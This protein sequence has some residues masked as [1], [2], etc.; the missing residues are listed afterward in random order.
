MGESRR[1][2]KSNIAFFGS[3]QLVA[4]ERLLYRNGEAV[5]LGSRQLDLLTAL[6]ERSGE[7]LSQRELMQRAWP[8][9][10]V[11]DVNLRVHIGHLRKI[12]RDGQEGARFITNVPGRGYCFVAPVRWTEQLRP[13]ES[14]SEGGGSST[15]SVPRLPPRLARMIGREQ[16]VAELK[17]MLVASRFVSV[18]G[19][20]G[21]GKTTTAVSVA[22][23]LAEYFQGSVFFV[24][25]APLSET[26]LLPATVASAVGYRPLSQN[27]LD[28]LIVFLL[29]RRV[30]LVL[31][32]CEHVIEGAAELTERL[33]RGTK[34]VHIL[35]TS[36]ESLRVEGE[37]VHLL[38][39]LESPPDGPELTV[40]S[41]MTSPA[42]RLFMDR[43][44]A[45]GYRSG[46][47]D[48]DA[49]VVADICR[50]LDGVPL[51]I[52]LV[53][54][55]VGVYGI[56]GTADLLGHRF[57]LL[58]QGR[59][60]A[61]PRHQTLSAM[62]DW[63]YNLLS[64]RDRQ[65]LCSL[66]VFTGDFTLEEAQAITD[67]AVW[68]PLDVALAVGSLVDKSLI[69]TEGVDGSTR[70]RLLDTTRGY[71]SAKLADSGGQNAA[72]RRHALY[73]CNVLKSA[74]I[75]VRS[76]SK[77]DLSPFAAHV[78][79]VRAALEWSFSS[80]SDRTIG[81]ELAA[82]AT[83]LFRGLFLLGD[84]QHWCECGLA[85]LD[86][87]D[88]GTLKELTLQEGLAISAMLTRGNGAEVRTAIERGLALAQSLNESHHQLQLLAGLHLHL[89][90]IN[91]FRGA[92]AIA[93]R[94]AAVAGN[95]DD[96]EARIMTEW[97]L[98]TSHYL[99]GKLDI[100]QRHCDLGFKHDALRASNLFDFF[101]YNHR[102]RALIVQARL[103]WLRGFP[104]R[105][106]GTARQAMEEAESRADP[107]N[108]CV[109]LVFTA[110]IFI[111]RGDF[112]IAEHCINRIGAYAARHGLQ[113]YGNLGVALQGEL[114]V[115]RGEL[116]DGTELLRGALAELKTER[117]LWVIPRFLPAFSAAL[118]QR[119]YFEE[120]AVA[121]DDMISPTQQDVDALE[122]P[123]LLR[124]RA[125]IWLTQPAPDPV[126]AELA[127]QRSIAT[128]R[129][130]GAL[131]LE[132]R[133]A[134][135]LARHW[136][137]ESRKKEAKELLEK[138]FDRFTEGFDTTDL[139]A[140]RRVLDD[141]E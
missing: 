25:L 97:M 125:E 84:C 19:T 45:G 67:D 24:D 15:P 90:I 33:V 73:F 111:R 61:L 116:V 91:D 93:E 102:I 26:S 10:V 104:D 131:A 121:I 14:V 132:L 37:N 23:G 134:T 32:N 80:Q 11:E 68:S 120:A 106:A 81:T 20:G 4:A 137:A 2:A 36:R 56:Q 52:E 114:A 79:N 47:T 30:L 49:V 140:A 69:W 87:S 7:V 76:F 70:F 129:L 12:L 5:V 9:L 78:D 139:K 74:T 48:A 107:V 85:E 110:G 63:S 27:P 88:R 65:V 46:L 55:R 89:I 99:L 71:A 136:L 17:K 98:G 75:D 66:S 86:D 77:R 1:S 13:L 18:V 130:Q 3:F 8:D 109:T 138:I 50:R 42:V 38:P 126:A 57:N 58:W 43:A 124:A 95:I 127:L 59:R 82:R 94:S 6:A 21:L 141:L 133:T 119:G 29:Q 60:S 123:E 16:S 118:V 22:H 101:G 62:L 115:A 113:P 64:S 28:G 112:D 105:A 117:A 54:G 72:A 83:P 92:L 128:A 31:D 100:A 103:H 40:A 108:R 44:I 96:V 35:T 53:A 41:A 51:A 39:P 135:V 122:M 34:E